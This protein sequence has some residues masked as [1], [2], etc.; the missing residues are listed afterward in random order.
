[1]FTRS[2]PFNLI[3]NRAE[4]SVTPPTT[5]PFV[6]LCDWA[7]ASVPA[8]AREIRRMDAAFSEECV[9]RSGMCRF[10]PGVLR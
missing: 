2:A 3:Q 8:N 9:V 5:I 4:L 10:T 6:R 7:R 1:M